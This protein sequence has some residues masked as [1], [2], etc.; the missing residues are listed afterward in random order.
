MAD[1][2][3]Y[4]NSTLPS[5]P[6]E[7]CYS[8][9]LPPATA[10]SSP[11]YYHV[12]YK[13]HP[14]AQMAW[15][16]ET[17]CLVGGYRLYGDAPLATPAKPEEE[18][19]APRRALKRHR[20]QEESDHNLG[21]PSALLATP[22]KAEEEKPAPRF[23]F[24]GMGILS[25]NQ[26]QVP[27]TTNNHSICIPYIP[28]LP[29]AY[30]EWSKY[31]IYPETHNCEMETSK[32]KFLFPFATSL[33]EGGEVGEGKGKEPALLA[34]PALS[35]MSL[36]GLQSHQML[37]P[38]LLVFLFT[39]LLFGPSQS[40]I[41][42]QIQPAI[43]GA[44]IASSTPR[45]LTKPDGTSSTPTMRGNLNFPDLR[46]HARALMQRFPLVDG[47]NDLPLVLRQV[48]RNGLHDANLRNFTYGQ[49]SLNRLRDGFVG[50]QFWSAYVPCQTQ[51]R[52]ALRLT[53]EQIDLIH[54]MCT[55]YSE[56][57]L[58]T[59]VKALNGTQ[60]LACLIGV[61]G[62]HSLDN[63]LSV[64][65]SFY[66]LEM[67]YPMLTQ[68]CNTPCSV[69]GL[70]HFAEKVVAEMNR[71]GVMVDLSHV[72]DNTARRALEVSQAP[73]IFSHSAAR[74]VYTN[75]RN[76][77]DDILWLL[78]KNGG[79]V[80]VTFS[81]GVLQCNP[82]ANVS[83][84]GDHFD[85]IR[86]VIGSEFIGI[87]GD[88]DG[89]SQFPQGLED[90]STYPVLIEELLRRGWNEHELQ[91][92]LRGNL[93]R[94]FRQVE[95]VREENRWQSPLEDIIPED[96]LDNACHSVLPHQHQKQY[97][98][99]N[100]SELTT[101]HTLKL[102][103]SHN[104]LPL[105]LK[106]LFQNKLQDVNLR[107]FT[108][109]QTSLDRLRDGLVGAQFW[110]AY[111]PCQ[112]Q[113]QDAVRFALEQIDLIRRMCAAYPELEL[114]TS[115]EG[116]NNTQ[117][118]ACLI[119]VEG[120]H[121]LDISLSVLRSF[122]QL[123][124]RYLT[125][126][127][128]CSTP[129]AESATKFRHHFY[130]NVSG[131][132]SFG[133]KVVE[134]MNRLGMMI[135]LSHASDA[136]VKQ[137]LEMSRAPVIFSHSAARAVCDNSLNVPDDILQLLDQI[138]F[139]QGPPNSGEKKKN[140]GI[141]MVTFSMGVL[142]CSLLANVSTVADHFDHIRTVI[143]SEFIGIGGNYDGSGR[144]P[145]G[146]EDVSTYPVLIEELLRRGWNEQE[147]QGVLRGNM[148]RVFGQVEQ[149]RERS[150]GQSPVEVKFPD[151]QQSST[152]HSH[153]LPQ[154]QEKHQDTYFKG[155]GPRP[156]PSFSSG[157][158]DTL[159]LGDNTCYSGRYGPSS[160]TALWYQ[161]DHRWK[162][163]SWASVWPLVATWATDN[164]DSG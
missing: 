4:T 63:S 137:T 119:G 86:A 73:V 88:Y 106:E 130:T 100:Q 140:G 113:D 102:S 37:T 3:V 108:H 22:T 56:L 163:R 114:V 122:Y 36:E 45:A 159:A 133:E 105:L 109:G 67:R 96:Q 68:I 42:T 7:C 65:R 20:V 116:L 47:H 101:H 150:L 5:V 76:L 66:Q 156:G 64:L 80:M 135:D 142:Q 110:S 2:I 29:G 70:T 25:G 69:K 104:D 118:L 145:Q 149:V 59:S 120:G 16:G 51:D 30:L 147:L 34:C 75:A 94:V 103:S 11:R 1:R 6:C 99:E 55:S 17:Y 121:S 40:L 82:L 131:L 90:V 153:L 43:F 9:S 77:P 49:T 157:P 79:I 148:L 35:K 136:L 52:D 50:A 127:F 48:Y 98:G 28:Q 78:R 58:V 134:E 158:K 23:Y 139:T 123:G 39:L 91:G 115:A 26:T 93:L 61:E 57:E 155:H 84:V 146:L 72:S 132:T 141:V 38:V 54:S 19:P 162:P 111:I 81:V 138:S 160:S 107:N 161:E 89:T 117:K 10:P 31:E 15:H 33:H 97:Q 129:W 21:H 164:T 62:G 12:L 126:T 71:L 87:G 27:L 44:S 83:T 74:G 112:T 143:G 85:H 95:Q 152:C 24:K 128:T 18:K 151:R 53:L 41:P 144:F 13:Q 92:V 60:K 124:V 46:D 14:Q 154:S 125:L 8:A 32:S